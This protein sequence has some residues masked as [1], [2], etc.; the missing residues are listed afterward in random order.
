MSLAE[1]GRH[2]GLKILALWECQFESA[3]GTMIMIKAFIISDKNKD[4]KL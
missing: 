4:Q 2:K 1:I 3:E